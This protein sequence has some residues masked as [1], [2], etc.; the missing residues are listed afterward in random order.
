MNKKYYL[1]IVILFIVSFLIRLYKIN[2]PL[3][4]FYSIRQV[5]TADIARNLFRS[6]FNI[7]YPTVSYAGQEPVY[8]LLEMPLYN[9]IIAAFYIFFGEKEIIGRLISILFFLLSS[10]LVGIIAKK[11]FKTR[12]ALIAMFLFNFFPLGILVSRA[13]MPDSLMLLLSLLSVWY[14]MKIHNCYSFKNILILSVLISLTL[15]VKIQ[16]FF[17]VFP[18]F[19]LIFSGTGRINK[20]L[21][22]VILLFLLSAAFPFIWYLRDYLVT[23]STNPDNYFQ[24]SPWWFGGKYLFSISFYRSIVQLLYMALTPTGLIL[25][26]AGFCISLNKQEKLLRF[27]LFGVLI[28]YLLFNSRSGSH[29]YYHLVILPLAAIYGA[30]I[31]NEGL[32]IIKNKSWLPICPTVAAISITFI[33][34]FMAPV[35]ARAY[36]VRSRFLSIIPASETVKKYTSKKDLIIS[37]SDTG[38]QVIYYSNRNGW[39]LNAIDVDY[40]REIPKLIKKGAKYLIYINPTTMD[41]T[42]ML[43]YFIK[44]YDLIAKEKTY[45]LFCLKKNNLVDYRNLI[46]CKN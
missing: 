20:K 6:G 21:R 39:S 13:F 32:T 33:Y 7:F 16:G 23:I 36:Y 40:V 19:Y 2:I 22:S 4:E 14:A 9:M 11:L 42:R 43:E 8:F 26:I 17:I 44:R 27:W 24:D 18:V 31:L 29:E 35:I 46:L 28:F 30:K 25:M 1:Y 5:H 10:I 34:L 12:T 45:F 15:L 38:E 41:D 3:L 37:I